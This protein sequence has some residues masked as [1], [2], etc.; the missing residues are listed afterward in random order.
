MVTTRNYLHLRNPIRSETDAFRITIASAFLIAAA[1]LVGWL[2]AAW[3]GAAAFLIAAL[4]AGVVVL[5]QPDPDR[6]ES[7]RR[8]AGEPHRLAGSAA[9][10]HVL[11]VAH[12][13]LAGDALRKR[14]SAAWGDRVELDILA[15]VLSSRTHL[16]LTDIDSERE[17]A[18]ERLRRSLHWA[19]EQGLEARGV[20]GDPSPMT[21]L[22][23]ELRAFGADE[24]ILVV[25]AQD[26]AP[27]QERVE[28]EHLRE[29]L[30]LPID[31]VRLAQGERGAAARLSH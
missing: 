10:R 25:A 13:T 14:I 4:A 19:R 6:P 12:E 3:V 11:V 20:V 1:A 16:M 26:P 8:A 9:R 5:H 7:L 23:D 28:L 30:D 24:V 17:A 2:T 27:W 21:A 22:E 15:P 31:V 18:G 29:E